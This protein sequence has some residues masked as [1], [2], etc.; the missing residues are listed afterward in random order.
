MG[1]KSR[2]ERFLPKETSDFYYLCKANLKIAY[3]SYKLSRYRKNHPKQNNDKMRI[4]FIVQRT[5]VFN[6]VR[7]I[8]SAAGEDP[9]CEVFLLPLPQCTNRHFELL[10][11]TY[12]KAVDFCKELNGGTVL[13]TYNFKTKEYFDL[14]KL[15]PDYI[16]LNVPYTEQYPEV[17]RLEK[18]ARLAKVCY[19]P[20]GYSI[21]N[22][23]KYEFIC[24]GN[25]SSDFLAHVSY[26]FCDGGI[27][28]KYCKKN[29]ILLEKI[30]EKHI[31]SFG[32]P[33]FDRKHIFS[34]H[35]KT[36]VLWLPRWT[37]QIQAEKWC[38]LGSSFF[39]YKNTF[40]DYFCMKQDVSLIIRPHP[41]AFDNYI[42]S[43]LMSE[44]DVESFR[45]KIR[46]TR[47]IELDEKSSYEYSCEKADILI[48]DFSSL[49]IEFFVTGKP[50]IYLGS[51]NDFSAELSYVTDTFFYASNW[52]QLKKCLEELC[53]GKDVFRMQREVAVK[54][55]KL[56]HKNVGENIKE[57]LVKD[58]FQEIMHG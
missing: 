19:V 6:S 40:L 18:L 39:E 46:T 57:Q 16:F 9:R 36:T 17:Y 52:S 13:E 14:E 51:Q 5:E 28:Y 54:K 37:T 22:E 34:K 23:K 49:I 38:N 25:Y 2:I 20:Y 31:Y 3:V 45:I 47:N 56:Q 58:W 7:T 53:D 15:N 30:E 33:R 50:I 11:D 48:A 10:W 32:Y 8:F 26:L 27:S 43:G 44:A 29:T 42:Q 12:S 1:S 41:L 35:E 21:L 55:F 4:V 24:Y